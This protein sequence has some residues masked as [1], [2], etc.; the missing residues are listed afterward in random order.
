MVKCTFCGVVIEPGTGKL[1]IK[2]DGKTHN[3]CSNKCQKNLLG[4]GRKA[5]ETT[6][7]AEH[8]KVKEVAE[9]ARKSVKKEEPKK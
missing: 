7:T 3:F 2:K 6:W 4:L 1:F 8:A 9:H 5:R